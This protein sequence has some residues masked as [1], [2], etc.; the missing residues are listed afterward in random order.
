MKMLRKIID[1]EILKDFR[2][3]FYNEVSFSK[4]VSL[5]CTECNSI[6]NILH[7]RFFFA[8]FKVT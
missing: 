5:Q 4:F 6:E 7:H 1:C 8:P 2:K 3:N